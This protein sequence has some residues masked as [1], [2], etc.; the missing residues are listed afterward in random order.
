MTKSKPR[1]IKNFEKL[2][3]ELRE[4]I[5]ALYPNGFGAAI[6]TFDIG[7]GRFMSALPYETDE[8]CYLIKFPVKEPEDIDENIP[9]EEMDIDDSADDSAD[10]DKIETS[11]G[12]L[13]DLEAADKN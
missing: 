4:E 2:S 5:S 13:E 6:Q 11:M 1:I 9:V 7:G 10:D 3:D 8:Y 12:S